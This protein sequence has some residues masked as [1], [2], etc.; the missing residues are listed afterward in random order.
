VGRWARI[1]C[2]VLI[3]IVVALASL[4][5]VTLGW[6]PFIGPRARVLTP[7]AFKRTPERLARGK[8]LTENLLACF[9]CQS[10]RDWTK[11][12]V[13]LIPGMEGGGAAPFAEQDLPG[14]VFPPNISPDLDTARK[15]GRT[16][17]WPA[18]FVRALATMDVPYSPSCLTLVTAI[19]RTK[20]WV[21]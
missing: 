18:P 7:R 19:C 20:T 14:K 6:R 17:N 2:G 13:P 4:I 1:L 8:Y 15:S 16:I 21:P 11:H 3:V 5:S 12:D 9:G 10:E